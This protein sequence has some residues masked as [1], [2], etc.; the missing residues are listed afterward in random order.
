M[1]PAT[2][3]LLAPAKALS[4]W[5]EAAFSDDDACWSSGVN[6]RAVKFKQA[7]SLVNGLPLFNKHL[8]NP[9]GNFNS[10]V[11]LGCINLTLYELNLRLLQ[12]QGQPSYQPKQNQKS[13]NRLNDMA[14][15]FQFSTSTISP[16]R[17][18]G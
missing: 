13:D 18:W 4:R 14:Y 15:A 8:R 7:G 11:H 17:Y 12:I 2:S 16:A 9:A 1:A 5:A 10:K 6:F 3:W